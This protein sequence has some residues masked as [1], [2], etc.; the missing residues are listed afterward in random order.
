MANFETKSIKQ[1][2][3]D[4]IARYTALMNKYGFL[5]PLLTKSAVEAMAWAVAGV[6]G[7][8]WLYGLYIYK[9]CF[10]QSCCLTILKLWGALIGVDYKYGQKAN[11]KIKLT[12]VSASI[13][14]A[15]TVFKH[16]S[17]GLTFKTVSQAAE[18]NGI[19]IATVECTQTGPLGNLEMGTFLNIANPIEGIPD[20]AD[21]VSISILGSTDEETETYRKRVLYKF[22]NKSQYGSPIDYFIWCLEVPGIKDVLPYIFEDGTITIFPIT[23]GSG[24]KRTPTGTL[25]PNPFPLWQNGQFTPYTGSGQML[26]LANSIEGSDINT[27]DRRP[28]MAQVDLK[29]HANY[30]PFSVEIQGLE[31]ASFNEEIK[32]AL[33]NILD[34]KRPEIIFID[35]PLK[36]AK[37]NKIQLTS[38]VYDVINGK[39]FT[40]FLLK[41]AQGQSIDE[42]ILG[43][44]EIAY[45]DKLTINE[46]L[47]FNAENE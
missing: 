35:Y 14:S 5:T 44:G 45:L 17:T 3:D 36:N 37:I 42:A 21:V 32:N 29:P 26:A 39:T 20:I 46:D 41:N 22:R 8:L 19:I 10:P 1:I 40:S 16:L 31:D 34:A 47:V 23:T 11:L 6:M 33:T 15:Q 30:V 25:T 28:C 18:E 9:Q 7:P 13:L 4:I 43:I 27:H 12:N 38:A 24:K 2:H